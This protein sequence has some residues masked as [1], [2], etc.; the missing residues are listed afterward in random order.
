M[1]SLWD[2]IPFRLEPYRGSRPD[3]GSAEAG[4]G[5]PATGGPNG[6]GRPMLDI[7]FIVGGLAVFGLVAGYTALCERL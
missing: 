1:R 3:S 6:Y 5:A 2:R 7:L 4:R